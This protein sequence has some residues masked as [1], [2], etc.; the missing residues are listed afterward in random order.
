MSIGELV[1]EEEQPSE[2]LNETLAASLPSVVPALGLVLSLSL[3]TGQI[4][5][6]TSRGHTK[7]ARPRTTTGL[8]RQE[9]RALPPANSAIPV[10]SDILAFGTLP[11]FAARIHGPRERTSLGRARAPFQICVSASGKGHRESR[12]QLTRK[13]NADVQKA[14]SFSSQQKRQENH[15]I[16]SV[17]GNKEGENELS[18]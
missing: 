14:R 1:E 5:G 18:S 15:I 8:P 16:C 6:S 4:A 2:T 3:A 12:L 10:A 7:K 9:A 17:H 11:L 13:R